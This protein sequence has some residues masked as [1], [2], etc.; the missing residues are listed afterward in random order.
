MLHKVEEDKKLTKDFEICISNKDTESSGW[1][2][3]VS[4]TWFFW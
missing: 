2:L 4:Y 3:Y 1:T